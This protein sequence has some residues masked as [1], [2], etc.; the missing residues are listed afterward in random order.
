ML[1]RLSEPEAVVAGHVTAATRARRQADAL[2]AALA[3]G[4]PTRIRREAGAA[5]LLLRA[6]ALLHDLVAAMFG[7]VRG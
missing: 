5:L 2:E 6:Q 7:G 4:D 1:S 3:S